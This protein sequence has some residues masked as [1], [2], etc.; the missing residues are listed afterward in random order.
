MLKC[1]D[2]YRDRYEAVK[3]TNANPAVKISQ[4]GD[5][6]SR[7]QRQALIAHRLIAVLG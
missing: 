2:D 7:S 1:R 4:L 3:L 6:G 5:L